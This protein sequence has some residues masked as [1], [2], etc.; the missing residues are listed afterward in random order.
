[1]SCRPTNIIL[2]LECVQRARWWPE[3][4]NAYIDA[5]LA[6]QL[7]PNASRK[8]IY[9]YRR[10]F[11]NYRSPPQKFDQIYTP[12][13]P[14]TIMLYYNTYNICNTRTSYY[15]NFVLALHCVYIAWV[16]VSLYF[17]TRDTLYFI[18]VTCIFATM[19][20]LADFRRDDRGDELSLLVLSTHR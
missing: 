17:H 2:L 14:A 9:L 5:D 13:L 19:M 8:H 15:D 6:S 1:M 4:G 12:A 20:N 11:Q 18:Y 16:S 3:G 7:F 10:A